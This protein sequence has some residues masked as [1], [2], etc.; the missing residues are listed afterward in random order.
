ML[1]FYVALVAAKMVTVAYLSFADKQGASQSISYKTMH[2]PENSAM[3]SSCL[4]FS[5]PTL[6]VFLVSLS[7]RPLASSDL[8]HTY[9]TL[10]GGH[11]RRYYSMQCV[12]S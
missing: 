6:P 9:L 1:W 7:R 8:L 4:R 11:P 3:M 5:S 12:M 10:A 2:V